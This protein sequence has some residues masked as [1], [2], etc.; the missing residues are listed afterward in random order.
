[1]DFGRIAL[2]KLDNLTRIAPPPTGID[3]SA[4]IQTLL[5]LGGHVIINKP[6]TYIVGRL[7]IGD[8]TTLE[9]GKGVTLKK[10]DGTN[11]YILVNKGHLT[12]TRNKFVHIKGGIWD[13][14][15][16]GNPTSTGNL[17]T[18]PQSWPGLGVLFHGVDNLK[19]TDIE[20]IGNE[21]KYCFLIADAT[22]IYA[23]TIDFNNTS[24]GLHFQPPIYNCRIENITGTT[25]DDLIAFTAGDYIKY[26]LCRTGN[27][28]NVTIDNV[29]STSVVEH[30]R[31]VGCGSDGNSIFKNFKISNLSGYVASR[32]VCL[33]GSDTVDGNIDLASTK[34]E[35][36]IIENMQPI[37]TQINKSC[38]EMG[39]KGNLT[40]KNCTIESQ[41]YMYGFLYVTGTD[42]DS[43]KLENINSRLTTDTI[44]YLI[45][46]TAT[47]L[48]KKLTLDNVRFRS[49][50]INVASTIMLL[51]GAVDMLTINNSDIN[52]L[53]GLMNTT[54]IR[55]T[56]AT[57]NV[58]NSTLI[59][60]LAFLVYSK[61]K[62]NISNSLITN[63]FKCI[64]LT[65]TTEVQIN[66]VNTPIIVTTNTVGSAKLSINGIVLEWNDLLSLL[67][68]I[69]GDMVRCTS[70]SEPLGVGVMYY[71][72]SAWQRF[73]N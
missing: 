16:T 73:L 58:S 56:T 41:Q 7:T 50:V 48:I 60:K 19:I 26:A 15:K 1:M 3:D 12:S 67:T 40:I 51:T 49:T 11:N 17:T 29:Y 55:S 45:N 65:T 54:F 36:I 46:T 47:S 31:L 52:I 24:D 42:V 61:A 59:T 70:A 34:V 69:K 37:F 72:G 28:E 43:I 33:L 10:K 4:N 62:I 22:N 21:S 20:N 68:P 9:L 35:N 44:E 63:S 27:F 64:Y 38:V 39:A 71:N 8:Y 32:S 6:G 25:G 2:S 30:V 23:N 13:L 57:I 14:N 53:S 18:N 5:D 66:A